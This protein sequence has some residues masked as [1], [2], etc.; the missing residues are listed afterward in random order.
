MAGK[1]SKALLA[2]TVYCLN[3]RMWSTALVAALVVLAIVQARRARTDEPWDTV[4]LAARAERLSRDIYDYVGSAPARVGAGQAGGAT[5]PED[6][7]RSASFEER[8]GEE[9]RVIWRELAGR[10]P[11]ST[12]RSRRAGGPSDDEVVAIADS[13]A[14]VARTL[15]P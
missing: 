9:I 15:R 12:L 7:D 2:A 13:L 8:F 10:V 14:S 1:T 5:R 3:P 6:L 4:L 11:V